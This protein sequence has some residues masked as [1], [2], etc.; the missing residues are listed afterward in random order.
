MAY[1]TCGARTRAGTPCRRPAGWGTW[2][3]GA[4]RCKLHGGS[5]PIRHG[6][7]S[8][9]RALTAADLEAQ[10]DAETTKRVT[11][12]WL[13]DFLAA[14]LEAQHT[15]ALRYVADDRKAEASAAM[16]AAADRATAAMRQRT[17]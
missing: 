16:V 17:P 3:P 5:T 12:T 8:K 15:A 10:A 9:V 14:H 4:G 2:H 11:V 1:D 13:V 6:L 7:R